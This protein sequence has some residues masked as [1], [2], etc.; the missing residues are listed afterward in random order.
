MSSTGETDALRLT[1]AHVSRIATRLVECHG[2]EAEL[3]A[4]RWAA[5]AAIAGNAQRAA[6]WLSILGTVSYGKRQVFNTTA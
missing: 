4:R 6:A 1:E 3:I 5:A 2:L